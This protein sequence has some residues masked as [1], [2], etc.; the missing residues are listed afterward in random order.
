MLKKYTIHLY[1]FL[2]KKTKMLKYLFSYYVYVV[3]TKIKNPNHLFNENQIDLV[4]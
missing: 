3:V 1:E 2:K 4:S